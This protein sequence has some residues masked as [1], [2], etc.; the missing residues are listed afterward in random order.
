MA[1]F[2]LIEKRFRL[3]DDGQVTIVVPWGEDG[4]ALC[5]RIRDERFPLDYKDFRK[6]QRYSVGIPQHEFDALLGEGGVVSFREGRFNV[7]VNENAY[8]A[9]RGLNVAKGGILDAAKT[10]NL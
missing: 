10:T 4:D 5:K 1:Q 2:R 8:D 3:I 9:V 7:L 6:A